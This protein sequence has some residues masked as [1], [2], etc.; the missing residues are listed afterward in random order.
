[1]TVRKAKP[2][3]I[4][5]GEEL[6]AK[7]MDIK[8]P[9]EKDLVI[10]DGGGDVLARKRA[11]SE[12]W[13]GA[14]DMRKYAVRGAAEKVVAVG[15][16]SDVRQKAQEVQ[17]RQD[18]L[19]WRDA[20]SLFSAMDDSLK[21]ALYRDDFKVK[22]APKDHLAFCERFG[23][24]RHL[25][26]IASRWVGGDDEGKY[27]ERMRDIMGECGFKDFKSVG[28]M[29]SMA[30]PDGADIK[31]L[32][33]AHRMFF[34]MFAGPLFKALKADADPDRSLENVK[35]IVDGVP[36]NA[37]PWLYTAAGSHPRS[38]KTLMGMGWQEGD[39]LKDFFMRLRDRPES[40]D[41]VVR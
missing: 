35:R 9:P 11:G 18:Y 29:L 33:A 8:K 7:V 14:D 31:T 19:A 1:M 12:H 37:K 23:F 24:D 34:A 17:A 15:D 41:G 30:Y 2:R 16:T 10:F 6:D 26:P 25:Y 4:L 21:I 28:R 27:A 22:G 32:D 38:V 39:R 13:V 5:P 3:I 20:V 40:F 36:A